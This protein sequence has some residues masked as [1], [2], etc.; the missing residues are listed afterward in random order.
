MNNSCKI[1]SN[2]NIDSSRYPFRE[3]IET[4]VGCLQICARAD[5]ICALLYAPEKGV[6]E[7]GNEHSRL[8]KKQLLEYFAGKRKEFQLN[9]SVK[10]TDF[11]EQVWQQ[12]KAIPFGECRSY[13]DIA[14]AINKPKAMRAVGAANGRNP[15]PIIVPCHRVIGSNGTLTGFA[16]GL[17]MKEWL[18]RH[19]GYLLV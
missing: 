11:Q 2:S 8:A 7:Q 6:I 13:G 16:G 17:A 18:L 14:Q 9:L 3:F 1:H 5:G 19:E 15:L 4:P 10:G 12:L